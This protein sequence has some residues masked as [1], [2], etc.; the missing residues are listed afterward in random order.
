[1]ALCPKSRNLLPGRLQINVNGQVLEDAQA[2]IASYEG[3]SF[4][5]LPSKRKL[6]AFLDFALQGNV[7][8][9]A[10]PQPK[11]LCFLAADSAIPCSVVSS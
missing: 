6:P 3:L 2:D 9:V 1:M 7:G 8:H 10:W 4:C 11:A 5:L